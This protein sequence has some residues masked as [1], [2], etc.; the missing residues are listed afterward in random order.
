MEVLQAGKLTSADKIRWSLHQR[1]C[2]QL[3]RLSADLFDEV[4][5]VLFSGGQRGQFGDDGSY[6]KAMR[7][8]RTKRELFDELFLQT[9]DENLFKSLSDSQSQNNASPGI[10]SKDARE[11]VYEKVEI[12]LALQA[13]QRKALKLYT[14]FIRQLE[15][16]QDNSATKQSLLA[17]KKDILVRNTVRA[18]EVAQNVFKLSL[19]VKLIFFKLFEQSL[20][21]KMEKM[22]LDTLSILNKA[23]DERFVERL[24]SSSTMFHDRK[25]SGHAN[26]NNRKQNI[27]LV[28]NS[29]NYSDV[30]KTNTS[31]LLGRLCE[32][33]RLPLFIEGMLTT[34]WRNVLVVIGV[35]SGTESQE[36]NEASNI[37]SSLVALFAEPRIVPGVID[38]KEIIRGI[39][40]GFNLIQLPTSEQ[41]EFLSAFQDH[42]VRSDDKE[43]VQNKLV[44]MTAVPGLPEPARRTEVAIGDEG[45]QVLNDEDLDDIIALLSV[46]KDTV[47]RSVLETNDPRSLLHFLE[48]VDSL[49]G[50]TD[51]IYVCN[52]ERQHCVIQKSDALENS[53]HISSKHGRVILT[54]SRLG[55]AI[56]FREAEIRIGTLNAVGNIPAPTVVL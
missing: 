7:E 19:E 51:G 15:S 33:N 46:E 30:V 24:Y 40:N 32:H 16:L 55:L 25:G 44:L 3:R 34:H 18:F 1:L 17:F 6:L 12:D 38:T 54:R 23:G 48:M 31:N 10:E 27:G 39:Q 9:I 2:E 49:N 14:P 41:Q 53:Y 47:S 52:G 11:T 36:W 21:L 35:N 5:D 29:E 28:K 26:V 8:I 13:M 22:Y 37:A 50:L 43:G 42:T 4:D 45:R 56:S 20:L